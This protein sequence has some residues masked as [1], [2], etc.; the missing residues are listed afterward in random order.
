MKNKWR[1]FRTPVYY[2]AAILAVYWI[3]LF[4]LT[5]V[6]GSAINGSLSV[7]DKVLHFSAYAVLAFFAVWVL[8]WAIQRPHFR[9]LWVFLLLAVYGAVDE[10]LQ[11]FVPHRQAD[12]LDWLADIAGAAVGIAIYY[13]LRRIY[14][15]L[16][17][18]K[19]SEQADG[20]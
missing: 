13:L 7:S 2:A 12:V 3:V 9:G 6:P 18:H 1:T 10:L 15:S 5:H 20:K 11:N 14:R 17:R 4:T 8:P 16:T 19:C